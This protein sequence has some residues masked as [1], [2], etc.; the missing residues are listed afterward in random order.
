[1]DREQLVQSRLIT[2]TNISAPSNQSLTW[3]MVYICF[4]YHYKAIFC[5]FLGK[6]MG[7]EW[8]CYT[9]I[10]GVSTNHWFEQFVYVP[11]L[12]YVL[13]R[14]ILVVFGPNEGEVLGKAIQRKKVFAIFLST[15]YVYAVGI[16]FTNTL[17]IFAREQLGITSGALYEQIYW[18]DETF[19]H[20]VQFFCYFLLFAWL[21][22][23]DRL[24]RTDGK[25][26]AISTGLAH[27]LERSIGVIEGDN[28]YSAM[29]FVVWI[30]IACI[31]RWRRHD[32]N[33][34]RVWKDYFF[35]HGLSF[36]ITFP[37]SLFLYQLVF[38][39]FVQPSEMG[40]G[41]WK[42]VVFAVIVISF[43][44]LIAFWVDSWITKRT[45]K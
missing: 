39:G 3:M 12:W 42:V 36:T 1:M 27:G 26:V 30:L 43:G 23:H 11:I 13:Y 14:L 33:F 19:S 35:R 28:A 18:I 45:K 17:E 16:H 7:Y 38:N 34:G 25:Y 40:I 10:H 9:I 31:I 8:I 24:D 5:G 21:I 6:I 20:W 32:R 2:S 37:I 22:A 41:A 44:F 29:I 15:M 4:A